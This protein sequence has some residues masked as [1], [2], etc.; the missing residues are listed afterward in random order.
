M[1]KKIL[2]AEDIDSINQGNMTFFEEELSCEKIE[3]V[4]YCDDAYLKI[5]KAS[6]DNTPYEL[7]ITDL[8]F[9]KDH[10]EQKLQSGPDLIKIIKN[11]YPETKII[12]YSIEDRPLKIKTLFN[13]YGID[14]YVCKGR[15]GL[16]EL[17]DCVK[18]V[19]QDK[20]YVSPQVSGA[21]T[22]KHVTEL[23][24]YDIKLVDYLSKGMTQNQIGELFKKEG[25]KPYSKSSIEKRLNILKDM[26]KAK[27][28][29]HLIAIIKDLGII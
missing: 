13:H 26:F 14:G 25:T 5:Q 23:N 24:E 27:N 20:E 4:Q 17:V 9:K 19:Y 3:E 18:E 8:S 28:V 11:K 1:F 7:L 10:R 6:S 12:G 16:R 22:S 15:N 29:I 21:L 2:I